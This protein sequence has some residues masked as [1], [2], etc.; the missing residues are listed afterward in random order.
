MLYSVASKLERRDR[1]LNLGYSRGQQGNGINRGRGDIGVHD[2]RMSPNDLRLKLI[3]K[4]KMKRVPR[5]FEERRKMDQSQKLSKTIQP[6]R[7]N[8]MQQQRS[9]LKGHTF[10]WR[11]TERPRSPNRNLKSSRGLSPQ[12]NFDELHQV[13]S[14]RAP[15]KSRTRW[16]L[17][18]DGASRPTGP[19][20][21]KGP[22]TSELVMQLTPI[23]GIGKKSFHSVEESH[24]VTSLLQSLGLGKYNIIFRAEEVDMTALKQMGDKDLKDMGIPMGPRK[25]I[26]L[27]LWPRSRREQP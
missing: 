19:L 21:V 26:L 14:L 8:N 2:S 12:R 23:G 22:D 4:R 24:T 7:H 16:I 6:A 15:D 20:T 18:N 1:F 5:V 3:N 11:A 27:A 25:K 9:E 13:P 17:S 10:L